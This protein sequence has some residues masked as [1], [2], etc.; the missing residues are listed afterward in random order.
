MSYIKSNDFKG[1]LFTHVS[2]N[3]I[4]LGNNVFFRWNTKRLTYNKN[5][6]NNNNN[7]KEEEE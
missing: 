6:F 5:I 2:L 7:K 3:K 1:F 4:L